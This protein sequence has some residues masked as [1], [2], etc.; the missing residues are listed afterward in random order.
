MAC[1]SSG[2]N[3]QGDPAN[4][5]DDAGPMTPEPEPSTPDAGAMPAPEAIPLATWVDHLVNDYDDSSAP[6]TVEDKVIE[7]TDDPDAF[8][9]YLMEK[10]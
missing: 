8:N 4:T 6:D 1:E 2:M 7:D 3:P 9:E 10:K 5:Q